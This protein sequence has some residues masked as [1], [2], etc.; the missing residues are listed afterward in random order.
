MNKF[1]VITNNVPRPIVFGYELSEEER[2]EFDYL[3]E[4]EFMSN[5]FVRYKGELYDLHDFEAVRVTS[6]K[7]LEKWDAYQSDSFFSGKVLKYCKDQD[8]S[9]IM[10]W[11]CT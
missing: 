5:Q 9:V 7:E 1:K 10:G 4:E 3:N 8:D 11:Y 2:K 6:N